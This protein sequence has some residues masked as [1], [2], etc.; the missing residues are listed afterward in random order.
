M[1]RRISFSAVAPSSLW[2]GNRYRRN[3]RTN[4]SGGRVAAEHSGP[5]RSLATYDAQRGM[6]PPTRSVPAVERTEVRGWLRTEPYSM[7]LDG[8]VLFEL[9]PDIH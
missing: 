1:I 7:W 8:E 6:A 5:C 9:G 4:E 3:D 2:C